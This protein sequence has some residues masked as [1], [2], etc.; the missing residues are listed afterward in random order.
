MI[1]GSVRSRFNIRY[2]AILRTSNLPSPGDT[3][4]LWSVGFYSRVDERD[5]ISAYPQV[6]S[7]KV[8]PILA[9]GNKS[10][11]KADGDL[12]RPSSEPITNI[13][14]LIPKAAAGAS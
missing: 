4:H 2:E 12:L 8:N 3:M 11:R 7:E 5:P 10:R 6:T 1:L 13:S 9:I 14:I